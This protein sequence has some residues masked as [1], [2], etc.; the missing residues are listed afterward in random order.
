MGQNS[1]VSG[2]TATALVVGALLA[3]GAWAQARDAA[4]LGK[5]L[6]TAG[7]EPAANKDGSIPAFGGTEAPVGGWAWGKKRQDHWKHKAEKP[8]YSIDASNVDKYAGQLSPGQVAMVKQAKGY[9]MD[10]YPSHRSCGVPDFVA[11]NTKKNVALGKLKDNGW[12]LQEAAL[13]GFPFPI[14]ENGAQAM[15]N[16][17]MRYRGLALDYKNVITA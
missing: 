17:K 8:L 12:A 13:P 14:P 5:D 2:R 15:W 11:E 1:F 6:T 4:R 10:V 7:A 3:C 16:A 9:R